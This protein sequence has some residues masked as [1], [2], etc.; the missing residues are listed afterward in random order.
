MNEV[1]ENKTN[2][3]EDGNNPKALMRRELDS[4]HQ[5]MELAQHGIAK[6]G[7]FRRKVPR[8]QSLVRTQKRKLMESQDAIDNAEEG[9]WEPSE[10]RLRGPMA[11]IEDRVVQGSLV[12][13]VRNDNHLLKN[14]ND[15]SSRDS[16]NY[17]ENIAE[18]NLEEASDVPD[19]DGDIVDEIE[20]DAGDDDED[21]D[22]S[23]DNDDA[24]EK[25]AIDNKYKS[26]EQDPASAST[27]QK[28]KRKR[29]MY[30]LRNFKSQ[31]L[32][33]KHGAA[34]GAHA[35]GKPM[36]AIQKLKQVAREAPSAPQIY[37][38]LGMVYEDMLQESQRKSSK[39]HEKFHENKP[40]ALK[41]SSKQS[42]DA[43]IPD[44]D[45]QEQLELAKKAYG[46]YHVSAILC[47]RDYSLWL[48]AA[49]SAS[50]IA[51]THA[52]IMGLLSIPESV[53]E[54]HREERRRWLEEA[55]NDYQAADNLQPPGI[56]IPGKLAFVL[57]ELG[58]ISDALTLLTDLKSSPEFGSSY[59]AW[60]LYSDLMLRLGHECTQWNRGMQDNGNYMFRRWLRKLSKSFDWK[61]RR[62]QGLSKALEAACGSKSCAHFIQ[63]LK[64]R[65][66]LALENCDDDKR[67]HGPTE[68]NVENRL[69]PLIEKS[70]QINEAKSIK[71][72]GESSLYS[73]KNR[74]TLEVEQ[75]MLLQRNEKELAYF[76]ET[77]RELDLVSNSLAASERNATRLNMLQNHEHSMKDLIGEFQEIDNDDDTQ[78]ES[79]EA[80]VTTKT[81][82]DWEKNLPL[83]A[84]CKTVCSIASELM[85]HMLVMNLH[86]G[87]RLVGEAVSQY[88]KERFTM[89]EKR[90]CRHD[91]DIRNLTNVSTLQFKA[92]DG[93]KD[94]DSVRDDD[95]EIGFSD[96]D[97]LDKDDDPA[98]LHSLQRGNLPPDLKVMYGLC[99]LRG[100]GRNFLASTCIS[101]IDILPQE[102]RSWLTEKIIDTGLTTDTN[103][104]L[105]SQSMT[106]P[107]GRTALYAFVADMVDKNERE[108]V[109][110]NRIATLFRNHVNKLSTSGF[111]AEVFSVGQGKPSYLIYRRNLV[112]KVLVA[113]ASK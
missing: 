73:L 76:D 13:G 71:E 77:T 43:N 15:D 2:E 93:I 26:N 36:E 47:K 90:K 72:D 78:K 111:V 55:K 66:I 5:E 70:D 32:A 45:L 102:R 14:D 112:I 27:K 109:F 52:S 1:D 54:Y 80:S 7:Q 107:L 67:W 28:P 31:R 11:A 101:D 92:Y 56:D 94:A 9:N 6:N 16:Q 46:A 84:S 37:S 51:N 96:D 68:D 74:E 24:V 30:R 82:E 48:R 41:R 99:L 39:S 3:N 79:N 100:G 81:V 34:L 23:D 104:L 95:T 35:L 22:I 103:W 33:Q 108:S 18:A 17:D 83:S 20:V 21:D 4:L 8:D 86:Q 88:F 97:E 69:D 75:K 44:Q 85:R 40:R 113:A 98:F 53:R 64:N 61:E 50:E 49:D 87:G 105:F 57:M 106:G 12:F 59:N 60:L 42:K 58:Q 29:S 110:T 65:V 25:S 89:R 91:N 19:D 62:L 38:S 10:R 63:W